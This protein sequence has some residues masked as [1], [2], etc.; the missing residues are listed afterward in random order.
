MN[1]TRLGPDEVPSLFD[2][3]VG[4]RAG[5]RRQGRARWRK[6]QPARSTP[7]QD[8]H[9]SAPRSGDARAAPYA[10]HGRG[11]ACR[12]PH[13]VSQRSEFVLREGR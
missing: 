5:K 1:V 3:Q 2:A 13:A 11:F 8:T 10:E 12:R 7:G 9:S 6:V 4:I